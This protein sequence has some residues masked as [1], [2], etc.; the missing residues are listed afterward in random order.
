MQTHRHR[1]PL[2]QAADKKRAAR[3]AKPTA[4]EARALLFATQRATLDGDVRRRGEEDVKK[5]EAAAARR[6]QRLSALVA[7]AKMAAILRTTSVKFTLV[8]PAGSD[9]PIVQ[10]SFVLPGEKTGAEKSE[11]V[12][13]TDENGKKAVTKT[14]DKSVIGRIRNFFFS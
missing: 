8:K 13:T 14:A 9:I 10:V 6:Q 12:A 5:Q 1:A 4:L 7:K 2:I 3:L 11:E